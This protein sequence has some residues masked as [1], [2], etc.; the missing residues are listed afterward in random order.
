MYLEMWLDRIL[1]F[2]EKQDLMET[3]SKFKMMMSELRD[4]E[5]DAA[6]KVKNSL[7]I[8][9]TMQSE[10]TQV[11]QLH[12]SSLWISGNIIQFIII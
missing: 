5:A 6:K 7:D 2:R 9:E 12:L 3:L 4:R 10:K 1:S 11:H 8:V